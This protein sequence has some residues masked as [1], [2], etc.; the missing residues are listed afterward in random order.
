MGLGIS[1]THADSQWNPVYDPFHRIFVVETKRFVGG[2][3][4]VI[5]TL[6]TC[7]QRSTRAAESKRR[8]RALGNFFPSEFAICS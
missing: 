2:F 5:L 4:N 3:A 7:G 6:Q 8:G 1:R